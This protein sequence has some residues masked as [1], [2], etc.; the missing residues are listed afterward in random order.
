M[1]KDPE[2]PDRKDW[3]KPALRPRDAATLILYRQ[4]GPTIEVLM[5]ERHGG[6]AFMP[7]RYVFP[8]GRVDPDDWRV[9]DAGTLKEHVAVRLA[10]SCPTLRAR[11]LAAAAIRETFEE[12]GLIIGRPDPS[13][14]RPVPKGWEEFFA[15]GNAPALDVLDYVLRAITPPYR[16]RRFNAR[17]FI[18][19]AKHVQGQIKGSGELLD[20]RWLPVEDA[21]RLDLPRITEIVLER[22]AEIVS[23]YPGQDHP[24]ALFRYLRGQQL[25]G[26]E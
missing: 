1:A 5:G 19:D 21:L 11:A 14:G 8:G 6:H 12:T 2:I 9:R 3:P 15:T 26:E 25:I 22:L 20:L 10:K 17:F 24:V 18:A 13:P 4:S 16:P 23:R 7:N